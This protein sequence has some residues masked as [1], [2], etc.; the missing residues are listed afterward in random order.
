MGENILKG[1]SYSFAISVIKI[2]EQ[3]IQNKK[4]YILSKQLT[5]SGTAIGAL[6]REAEFAQSKANFI[7]K[8]SISLKEAN[9]TLYRINLLKDTNYISE[10]SSIQLI[11]ACKELIS[12]LVASIK[13]V[14]S[15]L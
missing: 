9:E 3:I 5:R 10:E 11:N 4:E 8:M 1:K 13:T 15:K 6:I 2:S 14:K 7:N 12:I